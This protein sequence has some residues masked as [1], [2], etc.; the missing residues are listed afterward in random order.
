[1]NSKNREEIYALCDATTLGRRRLTGTRQRS[2]RRPSRCPLHHV[3]VA[4]AIQV[5]AHKAVSRRPRLGAE[6]AVQRRILRQA[7]SERGRHIGHE[8]AVGAARRRVRALGL[9]DRCVCE[10]RSQTLPSTLTLSQPP[11]PSCVFFFA[12]FSPSG[13][14]C[15]EPK[16]PKLS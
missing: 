14:E 4:D 2:D 16:S 1:M 9:G 8:L 6:D 13:L 7:K 11:M 15:A 10:S 3:D 12:L 5:A